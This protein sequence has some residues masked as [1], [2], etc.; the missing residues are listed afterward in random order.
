MFYFGFLTI[1]FSENLFILQNNQSVINPH[2]FLYRPTLVKM[3][4]SASLHSM[5]L[6]VLVWSNIR[7]R[8][9]KHVCGVLVILVSMV[10]TVWT[11]SM[12]MNVRNQA[13]F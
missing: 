13:C 5:I 2:V 6:F 7:E 3:E 1:V 9:V 4:E 10:A 8:P 12:D 11:F